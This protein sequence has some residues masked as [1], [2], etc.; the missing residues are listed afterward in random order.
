M[1]LWNVVIRYM[2]LPMITTMCSR[3][4]RVALSSGQCGRLTQFVRSMWQQHI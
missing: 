1:T 2:H 4:A 3:N